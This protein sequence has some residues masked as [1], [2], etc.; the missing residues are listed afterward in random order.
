VRKMQI[1][2]L[3]E[4]KNGWKK[5]NQRD[6]GGMMKIETIANDEREIERIEIFTQHSCDIISYSKRDGYTKII[7][8]HENGE[9]SPIVWFAIVK[10][11]IVV[12]RVNSK[13]VQCIDYC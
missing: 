10:A 3:K 4:L 13:Y 1:I 8:Y 12:S 9:M 11:D 6:K 5:A 7:P 2:L